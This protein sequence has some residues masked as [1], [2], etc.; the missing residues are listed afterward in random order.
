MR[1]RADAAPGCGGN[2]RS[3]TKTLDT[4][5]YYFEISLDGMTSPEITL[6]E[7]WKT[8]ETFGISRKSLEKLHPTTET[9]SHIY[10][11]LKC[12]VR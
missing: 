1:P 12:Q 9:I 6:E 5:P 2:R 7:M 8:L 10:R 11:S 4:L 3:R